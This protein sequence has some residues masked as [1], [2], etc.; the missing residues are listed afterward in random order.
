MTPAL[1]WLGNPSRESVDVWWRGDRL[2]VSGVTSKQDALLVLFA[3][4]IPDP[5][6]P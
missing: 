2:V 4:V 3:A 5:A 1:D 6:A